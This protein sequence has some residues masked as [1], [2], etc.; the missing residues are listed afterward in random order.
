MVMSPS[1]G[2]AIPKVFISVENFNYRK[3][4]YLFIQQERIRLI[5]EA[6][7]QAIKEKDVEEYLSNNKINDYYLDNLK[8]RLGIVEKKPPRTPRKTLAP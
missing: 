5:G 3:N 8:A 6:S 1:G 2:M 7:A 4:I